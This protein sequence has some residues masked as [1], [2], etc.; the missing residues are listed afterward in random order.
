MPITISSPPAPEL[1]DQQSIKD[2]SAPSSEKR[3]ADVLLVQE[4]PSVSASVSRPDAQL[5]RG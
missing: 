3:L 5:P 1:L 4:G 2:S